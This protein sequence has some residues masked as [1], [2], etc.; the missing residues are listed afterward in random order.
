MRTLLIILLALAV[1]SGCNKAQNKNASPSP[2]SKQGP[3]ATSTN[4]NRFTLNSTGNQP[5]RKANNTTTDLALKDHLEALAQRVAGVNKAH[6]VVFGNTAVVGI[7]V[8]GKLTR[9][10]VGNIKYSVAEA[11]RKDPRGK[12][13]LVT[14]DMDLSHRIAEIGTHIQKG[15]PVSGFAS[16][17]ADI[18]GRI[19]P[20]L[21]KDVKPRT[22]TPPAAPTSKH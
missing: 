13:T 15:Q 6:A 1:V 14:A 8:D 21:P 4:Y 5:A 16:E 2:Q 10:R 17:L 19:I 9:S 18:V 11:L 7:D 3:A 20:Q 22:Q 12:N